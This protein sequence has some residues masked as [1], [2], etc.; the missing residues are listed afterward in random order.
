MH[1]LYVSLLSIYSDIFY[2]IDRQ[3]FETKANDIS[4]TSKVRYFH[5][6]FLPDSVM[7]KNK[8][9]LQNFCRL[10]APTVSAVT[11]IFYKYISTDM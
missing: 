8:S 10:L 7:R 11:T 2:G 4:H 6:E 9:L 5:P 3:N 1:L